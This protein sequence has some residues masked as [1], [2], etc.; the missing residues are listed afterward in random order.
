MYQCDLSAPYAPD[1]GLFQPVLFNAHLYCGMWSNDNLYGENHTVLLDNISITA[2]DG[3][4]IP[5]IAL[6]GVN[7]DHRTYDIVFRNLT[8]NGR[9]ITSADVPVR[10]GAFA[11]PPV[12]E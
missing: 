2:E 11:D 7:A 5:E 9:K 12:I 3:V 4:K 10:L 8:F 1:A 6:A